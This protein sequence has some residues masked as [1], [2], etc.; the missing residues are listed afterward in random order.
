MHV[1]VG[2]DHRVVPHIHTVL[3]TTHT[4]TGFSAELTELTAL[5]QWHVLT[6]IEIDRETS[7]E[8]YKIFLYSNF[9]RSLA[10]FPC[11]L[12][13]IRE[14]DTR[15][16]RETHERRKRDKIINGGVFD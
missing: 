7:T 2:E 13:N 14:T 11:Q 1:V 15:Q 3:Y 9:C 16:K 10:T 6:K 4:G 5:G 12:Q 8:T